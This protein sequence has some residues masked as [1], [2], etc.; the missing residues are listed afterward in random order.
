MPRRRPPPRRPGRRVPGR[1]HRLQK[2]GRHDRSKPPAAAR[3]TATTAASARPRLR[4]QPAHA[5]RPRPRTPVSRPRRSLSARCWCRSAPGCWRATTW[6]RRSRDSRPSTARAP[7]VEQELKRYEKRGATARNRFEKQVKRT[8]TRFERELR[9]RRN[10][11]ERTVNQNR[12]R[13]RA[14]G[15]SVRKDIEGSTL[16]SG[17][18]SRRDR[19]ARCPTRRSGSARSSSLSQHTLPPPGGSRRAPR[20]ERFA[21]LISRRRMQHPLLPQPPGRHE[22]APRRSLIVRL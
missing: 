8:R 11:V 3:K 21:G 22:V 18:D 1:D 4:P 2:H 15:R 10:R 19:G 9:Q 17:S 5:R 14:R 7:A 16:G 13:R 6:S 20:R 12:R